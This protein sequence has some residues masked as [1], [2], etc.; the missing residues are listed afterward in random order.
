MVVS[1]TT[2]KRALSGLSQSRWKASRSS[3]PIACTDASVPDPVK[4]IP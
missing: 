4:G 3:F 1:P 2:M